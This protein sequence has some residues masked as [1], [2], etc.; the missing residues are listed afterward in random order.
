MLESLNEAR[1]IDISIKNIYS[2]FIKYIKYDISI[3]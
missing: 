3:A 1:V 2:L